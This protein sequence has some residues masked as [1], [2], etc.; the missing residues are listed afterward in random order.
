LLD[1]TTELV[2][3]HGFHAVGISDIGAAAGVTGSAIYRHF[4]T[5]TE[6]LVAVLDRVVDGLLAGADAIVAVPA[7]ADDMLEALVRA[8]VAFALRDRALIRIYAQESHH[9]PADDRRRLRRTMRAYVERWAS[10]L[11]VARPDLDIAVAR[12]RVQATFGLVNAVADLATP[13]S[14]DVVAGQLTALARA[15]LLAPAG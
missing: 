9:L 2:A 8:H 6:L 14:D 10:V 15:A 12:V 13:L 4:A 5:K 7:A 11:A 3:R 1:A